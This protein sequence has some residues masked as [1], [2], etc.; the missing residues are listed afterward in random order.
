MLPRSGLDIA[1]SFPRSAV[2]TA[3]VPWQKVVNCQLGT[4][5][6]RGDPLLCP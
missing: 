3:Q 5:P 4:V 6:L 1:G 2:L